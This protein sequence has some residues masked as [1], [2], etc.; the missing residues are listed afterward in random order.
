MFGKIYFNRE[1]LPDDFIAYECML[2]E[3]DVGM[4]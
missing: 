1:E 4:V 3:A 2:D